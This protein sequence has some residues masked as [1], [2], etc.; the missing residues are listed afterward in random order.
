MTTDQELSDLAPEFQYADVDGIGQHQQQDPP[1]GGVAHHRPP[2]GHTSTHSKRYEEPGVRSVLQNGNLLQVPKLR[3]PEQNRYV[4]T[5][6][7][8]HV[9][10]HVCV[11][12]R[13]CMCVCVCVCVCVYAC[14]CVVLPYLQLLMRGM[15]AIHGERRRN[16]QY[17]PSRVNRAT[18]T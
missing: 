9:C 10:A 4:H 6:V 15:S 3:D 7:L 14:V 11:C 12:V 13:V 18:T 17:V 2:H 8:M 1:I 16:R 5:I